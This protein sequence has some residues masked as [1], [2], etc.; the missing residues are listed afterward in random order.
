MDDQDEERHGQGDCELEECSNHGA[1]DTALD[2]TVQVETLPGMR[3]SRRAE[4]AGL[5]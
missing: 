1:E 5:C 2:W 3:W 4:T